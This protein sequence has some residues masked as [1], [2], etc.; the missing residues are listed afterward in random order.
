[1]HICVHDLFVCTPFRRI[2]TDVPYPSYAI[3][4][5][6]G[7]NKQQPPVFSVKET[8][9][10]RPSFELLQLPVEAFPALKPTQR[11]QLTRKPD[12]RAFDCTFKCYLLNL[13]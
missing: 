13:L 6:A 1:M 9:F 7:E 10:T 4:F 2:K 3:K 8:V 11:P 12:S 5:M